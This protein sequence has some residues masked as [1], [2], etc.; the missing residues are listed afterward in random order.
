MPRLSR[1]GKTHEPSE[2]QGGT[3]AVAPAAWAGLAGGAM[4]QVPLPEGTSRGP[5]CIPTT[6]SGWST[7]GHEPAVP[8]PTK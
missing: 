6:L 8:R 1:E 4:V 3:G 5:G 7:S 2:E